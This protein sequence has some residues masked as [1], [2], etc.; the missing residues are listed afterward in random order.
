[1]HSDFWRRVLMGLAGQ[2]PSP[3]Q[4]DA[5][6]A[7]K[8]RE[9]LA[10]FLGEDI[11]GE[12]PIGG[13]RAVLGELFSHAEASLDTPSPN[14]DPEFWEL[15]RLPESGLIVQRCIGGCHAFFVNEGPNTL[16]VRARKVE[17]S[18]SEWAFEK[19][20]PPGCEHEVCVGKVGVAKQ[21]LVEV[22]RPKPPLQAAL[23]I[24]MQLVQADSLERLKA[25]M[26][27]VFEKCL[28]VLDEKLAEQEAQDATIKEM[29]V[30]VVK[31]ED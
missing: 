17:A 9:L 24:P 28:R 15:T 22:E 30:F 31:K 11:P 20:L 3:S 18:A 13:F 1:M 27:E 23:C 12:G 8:E 16:T 6:K 29:G 21:W 19:L 14:G 26:R 5:Q 25:G 7:D 2:P 4:E 10:A